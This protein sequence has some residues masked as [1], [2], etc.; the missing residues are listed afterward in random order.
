MTG[1]QKGSMS[2]NTVAEQDWGRGGRSTALVGGGGGI[3]ATAGTGLGAG[4]ADSD[5]SGEEEAWTDHGFQL[6]TIAW[7]QTQETRQRGG[8]RGG[9]QDT[10]GSKHWTTAA[11]PVLV[12]LL[13]LVE[14]LLLMIL[15]DACWACR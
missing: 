14:G 8:G 15:I 12:V 5:E 4:E 9:W 10:T 11:P 1:R 3:I 7:I 13:N 6:I 2:F